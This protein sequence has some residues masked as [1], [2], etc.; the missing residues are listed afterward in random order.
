M[1]GLLLGFGLFTG[2]FFVVKA[3]YNCK[4]DWHPDEGKESSNGQPTDNGTSQRRVLRTAG[5]TADCHGII[6][7]SMALAVI[8][9]GLK[10]VRPASRAASRGGKPSANCSRAKLTIR[11]LLAEATPILMIEPIS[12]GTD[13]EV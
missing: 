11:I 1:S 6:P 9:T 2:R 7:I 4:H 3:V 5:A 8:S 10:R 13:K 12:A